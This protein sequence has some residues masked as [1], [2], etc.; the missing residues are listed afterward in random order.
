[1][2]YKKNTILDASCDPRKDFMY[3]NQLDQLAKDQDW[4]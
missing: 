4:K 1:M 2:S 3:N